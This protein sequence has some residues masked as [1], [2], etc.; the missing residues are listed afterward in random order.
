M[1]LFE[2]RKIQYNSPQSLSGLGPLGT[3]ALPCDILTG[4]LQNK[5]QPRTP[6]LLR[7]SAPRRDHGWAAGAAIS[8][9]EAPAPW[10]GC[11]RDGEL[12]L[13]GPGAERHLVAKLEIVCSCLSCCNGETLPE[14]SEPP[15]TEMFIP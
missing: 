15:R 8:R 5:A 13:P 10:P 11:H 12:P 2:K 1:T 14:S 4:Q 3:A 9:G 6:F 7:A